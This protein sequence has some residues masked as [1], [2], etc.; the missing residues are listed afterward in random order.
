MYPTSINK[1]TAFTVKITQ[2]GPQTYKFDLNG[3]F[4]SAAYLML[5]QRVR[6]ISVDA[7][8]DQVFVILNFTNFNCVSENTNDAIGDKSNAF[9]NLVYIKYG[10]SNMSRS[11]IRSFIPNARQSKIFEV[12][13]EETALALIKNMKYKL[14]IDELSLVEEPDIFVRK[15]YKVLNK[16]YKVYHHNEWVYTSEN[17]NYS[18]SI[19]LIDKNIF[20]STVKGDSDS[21]VSKN[22]ME[23]YEKVL[24][25]VLPNSHD[26]YMIHDCSQLLKSSNKA[27]REF[28]RFL[29]RY[30][31][32]INLI[33]FMGISR[34]LRA[35]VLFERL[36]HK[37]SNKTKIAESLESSLEM[38]IKHK[39]QV[40]K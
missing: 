26:F 32:N 12:K 13:D 22:V 10:L 15:E 38:I 36:F 24:L 3:L 33:V 34:Y 37:K 7:K 4:S 1:K 19:D 40:N 20:V 39:Y 35:V 28:V 29:I 6:Q 23:L 2:L 5:Y 16:V 17:N 25:E 21:H 8:S 14:E 11:I 31:K 18:F 30:A 9:N 27:Q